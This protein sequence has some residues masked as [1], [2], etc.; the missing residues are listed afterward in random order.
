[1][2]VARGHI[3]SYMA[4][5]GSNRGHMGHLEAIWAIGEVLGGYLG[6]LRT[7]IP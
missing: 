3:G 6:A 5:L 4:I 1:M 7:P 2:G